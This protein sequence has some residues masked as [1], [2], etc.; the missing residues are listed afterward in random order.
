MKRKIA[1][2]I[3]RYGEDF[4][5]GAEYLCRQL[6]MRL[7]KA[8]DID[9]LTTCS[10]TVLPFA[11][12]YPEGEMEDNG[13]NVI[14]FGVERP[15]AVEPDELLRQI[16]YYHVEDDY[17]IIKKRGPYCLSLVKY[18]IGN[19]QKYHIIFFTTAIFFT[20]VSG[21]LLNLD[22]A[23]LIP[24]AHDEPDMYRH[25]YDV[26]FSLSKGILFN[27]I[28]ERDF[29][30]RRFSVTKGR[31]TLVTCAGIEEFH[32]RGY[33]KERFLLYVGRVCSGK[34]CN[35]L[36][37]Y[38]REYKRERQSD[39]KLYIAGSI[40]ADYCELYC[41][42]VVYLGFITEEAKKEMME[43]A[44]LF[45]VP[46]KYESLSL[47][48]LESLSAGTPVIVN[49]DC[50]VLKGQ[51]TRSNAG[52]YYSSYAEFAAVMDYVSSNQ[53]VY[54]QMRRNG[55]EFVRREYNWVSE[56]NRMEHFIEEF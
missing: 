41:K 30:E 12:D 45:M 16:Q 27:S 10:R 25:I 29:I 1:F 53:A 13:L 38:F 5:G 37:R 19:H 3:Q 4:S 20:T 21:M 34:G 52:L 48:L 49:E 39:L 23:V 2:V 17:Q 44:W 14:R 31:Q 8:F 40:E 18:L 32:H 15:E 36:V 28:E 24:T 55:M 50:A 56:I 46:S 47:V 26:V 22:N 9:V 6:A 35:R 43:K 54:D 51:C 7:S 33:E 42:D 11:N